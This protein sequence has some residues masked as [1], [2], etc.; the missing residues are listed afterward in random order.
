MASLG[1]NGLKTEQTTI[2][3]VGGGGKVPTYYYNK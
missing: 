1:W 3:S 2:E